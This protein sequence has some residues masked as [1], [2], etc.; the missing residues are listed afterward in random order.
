MDLWN[1]TGI[2]FFYIMMHFCF[3]RPLCVI[4]LLIIQRS[5]TRTR[6]FLLRWNFWRLTPFGMLSDCFW[7][8]HL[9]IKGIHIK[10]LFHTW[11]KAVFVGSGLNC[12]KVEMLPC[13]G[14]SE[15]MWSH[16]VW[17]L[18][19]FSYRVEEPPGLVELQNNEWDPV[20]DWIE[21]R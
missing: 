4:Q 6:W 18:Y 14:L 5:A 20:M 19:A 11:K 12:L 10:H 8:L 13:Q 2:I 16:V 17:P 21:K 9:E 7:S 1:Y 3:Y 15:K